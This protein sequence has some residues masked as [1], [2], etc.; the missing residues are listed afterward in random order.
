M[1]TLMDRISG[2][3]IN[4]RGSR[5]RRSGNQNAQALPVAAGGVT[6]Q[7]SAALQPLRQAADQMEKSLFPMI[8]RLDS[9]LQTY[10]RGTLVGIERSATPANDAEIPLLTIEC[11]DAAGF[12]LASGLAAEP[13]LND[14][15]FAPNGATLNP[16][17]FFD[18]NGNFR[19]VDLSTVY[20][21]FKGGKLK[22]E[23]LSTEYFQKAAPGRFVI[24]P[25]TSPGISWA[26][27][28][29][30]FNSGILGNDY[31]ASFKLV[32]RGDPKGA[33]FSVIA[34]EGPEGRFETDGLQATLNFPGSGSY[35]VK[36]YG[37]TSTYQSDFVITWPVGF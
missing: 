6:N 10:L 22:S 17:D 13:T 35:N 15:F 2:I 27:D 7:N 14:K 19:L 23:S 8:S 9:S 18:E 5:G 31:V 3:P 37:V 11:F 30:Q 29:Q 12:D 28:I 16:F 26:F 24:T 20:A 25:T 1:T 32:N 21:D 33:G 4:A 34:W 36:V